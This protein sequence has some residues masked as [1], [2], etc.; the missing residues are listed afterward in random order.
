MSDEL[1][2]CPKCGNREDI[3]IMPVEI[4]SGGWSPDIWWK[5]E[6]FECH[7]ETDDMYDY[8]DQ[9]IAAWN[10]RAKGDE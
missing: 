8:R 9:A 6:C 7:T 4:H 10:R 1:K 2:P 5:V 3:C